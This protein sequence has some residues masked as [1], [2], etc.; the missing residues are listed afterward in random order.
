M[1]ATK[2]FSRIR[3]IDLFYSFSMFKRNTKKLVSNADESEKTVT[4]SKTFW[5]KKLS[6]SIKGMKVIT[7]EYVKEMVE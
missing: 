2:V 4:K 1:F 7:D 6:D 3:S 5:S